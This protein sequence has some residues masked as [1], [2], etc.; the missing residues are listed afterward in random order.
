MDSFFIQVLSIFK[1][2]DAFQNLLRTESF[3][4]LLQHTSW[5]TSVRERESKNLKRISS[6]ECNCESFPY[7]FWKQEKHTWLVRKAGMPSAIAS[8]QYA[9]KYN[10]TMTN[11]WIC[12]VIFTVRNLFLLTSRTDDVRVNFINACIAPTF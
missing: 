6:R 10:K 12:A 7:F 11:I 2:C 9:P 8:A 5:Y 4:Y 1:T 3:R